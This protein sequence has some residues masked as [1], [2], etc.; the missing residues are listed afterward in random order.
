M[1]YNKVVMKPGVINKN[2][3]CFSYS[4]KEEGEFSFYNIKLSSVN[5]GVRS[6]V[7][8]GLCVSSHEDVDVG[9]ELGEGSDVCDLLNENADI[10][11][12]SFSEDITQAK[13]GE[14]IEKTLYVTS[15]ANLRI[16]LSIATNMNNDFGD[17]VVTTSPSKPMVK[18]SFKV[19]APER[20]GEFEMTIIA[21]ADGCY[22]QA[23]KKQKITKL[24]VTTDEKDGFTASVAPSNINLKD[25]MEVLFKITVKNYDETQDFE[26]EAISDPQIEI[27]P[28]TKT[29]SVD[30]DDE[31]TTVFS[32]MPGSEDLY[33]VEFKI[34][35]DNSEK[36]LS[37]YISI[38]ELLNDA[39]RSS[40]DAE[41][42]TPSL[43][44]E[45]IAARNEYENSY[46]SE[47]YGDELDEYAEFKETLDDLKKGNDDKPKEEPKEEPDEGGLSWFFVAIPIII[48]AVVVLIFFMYKKT[49]VAN[50][51][52][53]EGYR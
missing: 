15:Y 38:G 21:Q 52:A 17:M 18:K 41:R 3:V 10:I 25:P 29:M 49:K 48:I 42:E 2:P 45:I 22:L 26:I 27:D 31:K 32:A 43:R 23:C 51:V 28:E 6:S 35:T 40:S 30:K 44:D 5:L 50:P 53:Y 11:D 13:P 9:V 1:T 36:L 39:F 14:L 46:E 4:D 20:E 19:K 34:I 24:S 8:G 12:L 16:K 47:S 7:S 37:A 33:K